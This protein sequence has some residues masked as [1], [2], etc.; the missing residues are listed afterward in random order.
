M[1]G[2]KLLAELDGRPLV[3]HA[4]EAALGSCARP[5]VVVTGND[6]EAVCAALAGLDIRVVHNPDY[7]T[8]MANS[9]AEA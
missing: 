9:Y 8:G 5:V 2:N 7:A 3:R 4:V 6:A 1:G